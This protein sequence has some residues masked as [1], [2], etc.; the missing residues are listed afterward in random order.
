MQ[1]KRWIA[2]GYLQEQGV[3]IP[4]Y[5]LLQAPGFKLCADS[6][7]LKCMLQHQFA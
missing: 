1:G 7:L 6:M 5:L 3:P 2:K 4:E